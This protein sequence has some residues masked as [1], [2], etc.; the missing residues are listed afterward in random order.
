MQAPAPVLTLPGRS[1]KPVGQKCMHYLHKNCR[2]RVSVRVLQGAHP[3]RVSACMPT[4]SHVATN[5][6]MH[7]T[8]RQLQFCRNLCRRRNNPEPMFNHHAGIACKG[9]KRR[10]R[11]TLTCTRL[12]FEHHRNNL[13]KSS[14]EPR[15][16]PAVPR[17]K[18]GSGN[19]SSAVTCVTSFAN[20]HVMASL[21]TMVN[22]P[23]A[24]TPETTPS[25]RAI[26]EQCQ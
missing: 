23:M 13:M 7:S 26:P 1:S 9:C 25:T 11:T 4:P 2:V 17:D 24:C 3:R 20:V 18:I 14:V 15:P 19:I 22:D 6:A 21:C 5:L 16:E 12:S 8:S 10:L